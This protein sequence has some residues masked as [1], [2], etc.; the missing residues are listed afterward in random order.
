[1]FWFKADRIEWLE[2][3]LQAYK[4]TQRMYRELAERQCND[5]IKLGAEN[6][7]LH[8]E[9]TQFKDQL[10]ETL[11]DLEFTVARAQA[12]EEVIKLAGTKPLRKK[13]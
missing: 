9:N 10:R 6:L 1:M 8:T 11:L 7:K 5:L 3:N 4:D 13:K 2:A 12:F